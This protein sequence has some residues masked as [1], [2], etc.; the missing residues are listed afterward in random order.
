MELDCALFLEND[1]AES[2][3]QG[4]NVSESFKTQFRDCFQ[5]LDVKKVK[6]NNSIFVKPNFLDMF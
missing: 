1:Y 2:F 3:L 4:Q 5:T 6:N